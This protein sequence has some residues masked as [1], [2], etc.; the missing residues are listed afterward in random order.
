MLT[1]CTTEPSKYFKQLTND[2]YLKCLQ[3]IQ[4]FIYFFISQSKKKNIKKQISMQI[5]NYYYLK[6]ISISQQ[7]N[8]GQ[9]ILNY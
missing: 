8:K 3:F 4:T 9:L 2:Q 6:T 1:S 7:E 5:Q